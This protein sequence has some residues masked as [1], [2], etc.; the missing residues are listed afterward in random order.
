MRIGATP[1]NA[2]AAA[3]A[4]A[5]INVAGK[6]GGQKGLLFARGRLLREPSQMWMTRFPLIF[7]G[8]N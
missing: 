5:A 3:K 4:D 1:E 7:R 6:T 2:N 8:K